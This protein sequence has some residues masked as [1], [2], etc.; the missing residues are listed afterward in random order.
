MDSYVKPL[1][2]TLDPHQEDTMDSLQN[3][4]ASQAQSLTQNG[5]WLTKY[6]I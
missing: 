4:L 6:D 5:K 1:T 2:S 3:W